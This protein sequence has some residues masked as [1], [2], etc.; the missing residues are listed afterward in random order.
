[1]KKHEETSLLVRLE[2]VDNVKMDLN[3]IGGSKRDISQFNYG[4]VSGHCEY[5]NEEMG[6]IKY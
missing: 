5:G 1:V 3:E 2:W 4:P 6:S